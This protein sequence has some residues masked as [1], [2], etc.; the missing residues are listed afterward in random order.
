MAE[1]A[2]KEFLDWLRS[3]V[4]DPKE[5]ISNFDRLRLKYTLP[6]NVN[7]WGEAYERYGVPVLWKP[8]TKTTTTPV[9]APQRTTETGP[10]SP[11]A[12][13]NKQ[14][15]DLEL[16]ISQTKQ[17]I[18]EKETVVNRADVDSPQFK[19]ASADLKTLKAELKGY[20]T[21]YDGLV[22]VLKQEEEQR[23]IQAKEEKAREQYERQKAKDEEPVVRYSPTGEKLQ[24]G[25]DDYFKGSVD[26]PSKAEIKK[27]KEEQTKAATSKPIVTPTGGGAGGTGGTGGAGEDKGKDT[28]QLWVSYLR[29]TFNALDDKKQKNQIDKIFEQAVA[30]QWTETVFMENLKGT[31]WWQNT[32]PSLR[33][34]FLES[35][36]KRNKAVFDERVQN[37]MDSISSKLEK[38][39][40]QVTSIDEATGRPIDN[41][42]YLEGIALESMKNNFTDDDL[43]E[44]LA[45]KSGIIFSG[46]GTIGSNFDVIKRNAYNYG[47]TLDANMENTI[48]LSL[49]DPMDGRDAQYWVNSMKQMALDAPQN[50]PFLSALKEGRS[51]YEVT[52]SYRKQMADLLE[53]DTTAITWNDLMGKVIDK[54]TG[55]ARTFADFNKQ[56][57]QDPLWQYTK[58]A[59]E[60]YSNMA[61]DIARMFGFAG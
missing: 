36:D 27:A 24:P 57:K 33:Q 17:K 18:K 39:G 31:L 37:T 61:L 60:T 4:H 42:E 48:N 54:D 15:S 53:V 44:Y 55:N 21:E 16:K 59:K 58:N 19:Q 30:N 29:T 5:K 34:F 56:L 28:K 41:R 14:I 35:H 32:L 26:K 40:I 6:S 10:T 20:Q 51:L 46:G 23:V 25:T 11:T 3:E 12:T 52:N 1:K 9:P 49:L 13:R 50:K 38:L 7:T 45:R 43:N 8:E 2:S 47:I 22:G